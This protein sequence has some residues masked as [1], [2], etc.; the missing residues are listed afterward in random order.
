MLLW[1]FDTDEWAELAGGSVTATVLLGGVS[2]DGEAL[3]L[4]GDEPYLASQTDST[5]LG[6]T[7]PN[8]L[9][10]VEVVWADAGGAINNAGHAVLPYTQTGGG[11]GLLMWTGDE[12]LVITDTELKEPVDDIAAIYTGSSPEK[13]RPG[14]SGVLNDSDEVVFRVVLSDGTQRIY[15]GRAD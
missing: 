6:T 15:L 12:L 8:D 7:L 4:A 5:A 1:S 13:D 11:S 10:G 14:V 2:D 3:V 9:D